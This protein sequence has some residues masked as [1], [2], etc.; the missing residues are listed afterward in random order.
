MPVFAYQ[1]VGRDGQQ[2]SGTLD[3]RDRDD[4]FRQLG[5]RGL[6][7]FKLEQG[8][9]GSILKTPTS[10]HQKASP[11][12]QQIQ[13][14]DGIRLNTGQLVLFTEAL[15]DLLSAGLQLEP[16]LK[17]ME[18]RGEKSKV[19]EVAASLRGKIRDGTSFANALRR[20]SPSF[21]ELYC[22]LA[23]AGEISG[24]LD[25]ILQR[26]AQYLL[27][28]SELRSKVL[29]AMIYPAF[30][31]VSGILVTIVFVTYLIPK[32]STLIGMTGG[33]P[34]FAAKLLIASSD[35]FRES[36][37]LIL[38]VI[39]GLIIV[40][41]ILI[42]I[43]AN[44]PTWDRIKLRLPIFGPLQK[45]RF[46]VQILETLANVIGNGVPMLKGLE[47]AKGTTQNLFL[48][49]QMETIS[50]EVGDGSSLSRSFSRSGVFPPL[51]IDLIRV[52]E[53]TGHMSETLAKAANRF[54]NELS[55][56][57]EQVSAIVQPAIVV[58]MSILVGL[59]AYVM[60]SII[61]DT[62]SL[63]RSR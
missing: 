33:E 7:P 15:S 42:Q 26:Q 30:L 35:F 43:P 39:G 62:I 52:G 29:T 55:K 36:W 4:A 63:L 44:R 21:S 37:W 40:A 59:M 12:T 14:T 27:T 31:I 18:S 23:S 28:M 24:S 53:Q 8:G 48:R 38:A 6:Q 5:R 58:L 32:L 56:R 34:P 57:I 25:T 11:A 9:A 46:H 17:I 16:A 50:E 13:S 19:Q 51:L 45:T 10:K 22:N 61:Y 41:Q 60:I 2:S 49:A 20:T 54:D 1:A 3:A 47:L